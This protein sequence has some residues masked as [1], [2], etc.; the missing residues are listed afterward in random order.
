[1]NN[2][3]FIS[4]N[5]CPIRYAVKPNDKNVIIPFKI[6]AVEIIINIETKDSDNPKE[7]IIPYNI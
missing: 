1:M 6:N 2:L 3:I 4:F 5:N 7:L